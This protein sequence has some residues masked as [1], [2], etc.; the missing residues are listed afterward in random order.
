MKVLTFPGY[1]FS[2]ILRR[3]NRGYGGVGVLHKA[4][5]K[6]TCSE[7]YKSDSLENML[8]QFNTESQC[9]N[10]VTIYRPPPNQKNK[11]TTTQF[12]KEFS[13]F[14]QD[15]VT[16]SGDLLIVEVP[17]FTLTKRMTVLLRNSQSCWSHSTSQYQ[18][19]IIIIIYIIIFI[20]MENQRKP[21]KVTRLVS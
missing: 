14:L 4:S 3:G 15:R 6:V 7:K 20:I 5:I 8:I 2:H 16:S 11:F 17:T 10:L 13:T 19:S 9:L 12:F 21:V 18:I 1:E